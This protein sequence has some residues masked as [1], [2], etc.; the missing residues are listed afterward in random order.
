MGR[1][2]GTGALL[3]LGLRRDRVRLVVWASLVGLTAAGTAGATVDLYPTV[4]S[5]VEA[6]TAIN[7]SPSLVAL[8]GPILD[9]TSLGAL[10]LLKLVNLGAAMVAVLAAMTTVRHSRAEEEAGRL[11]LLGATVLGRLAPFTAGVSVGVIT[12]VAVGT[13]CTLGLLASGLPV[14]GSVAFGAA[15]AGVGICFAAAEPSPTAKALP[16]KPCFPS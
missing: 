6:A 1:L 8:Y 5:R 13:A 7:S 15:W 2:A 10:S 4:A 9:P 14:G 11:E 3:R 12:S 16:E